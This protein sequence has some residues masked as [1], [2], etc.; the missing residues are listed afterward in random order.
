M[1]KTNDPFNDKQAR[2]TWNTLW[3]CNKKNNKNISLKAQKH[4]I[5]NEDWISQGQLFNGM[6]LSTEL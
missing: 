2:N 6:Q 5:L 3:F 4:E 1:T